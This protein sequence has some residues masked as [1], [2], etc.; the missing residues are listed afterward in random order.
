VRAGAADDPAARPPPGVLAPWLAVVVAAVAVPWLLFPGLAERPA[1]YA[2]G[3][4]AIW[5]G[6]WPIL[7]A[8]AVA[9]LAFRRLRHD[10]PYLP[11]GDLVVP[12][13]RALRDGR[14]LLRRLPAPRASMPAPR[15]DTLFESLDRLERRLARWSAAGAILLATA[16]LV[17]VSLLA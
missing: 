15:F 12:A 7:A 8:L 9:A 5:G 17:G 16:I 14:A 13:E 10:H 3:L 6:L 2:L 11:E 4:D 1:A